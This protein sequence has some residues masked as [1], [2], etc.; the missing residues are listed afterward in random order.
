MKI[1]LRQAYESLG[2]IGDVL[3]VKNGFARNFL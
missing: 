1:I 3:N 2:N